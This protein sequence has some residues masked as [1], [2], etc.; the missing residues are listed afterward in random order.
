MIEQV[1]EVLENGKEIDKSTY[2]E[3]TLSVGKSSKYEGFFHKAKSMDPGQ[4]LK[5]DNGVL[6]SFVS[7]VRSQVYK[8]NDDDAEP[9]ERE[10]TVKTRK[11]KEK[12]RDLTDDEGKKLY[13][14]YILRRKNGQK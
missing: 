3:E 14:F 10:F 1:Q 11:Q 12:G 6:E 2:E 8:L 9:S 13:T 7:G 5:F 4:V